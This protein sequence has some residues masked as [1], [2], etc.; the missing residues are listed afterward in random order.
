MR[1]IW[2]FLLQTLTVSLVAGIILLVKRIFED[3]LSPRWQYG[4]W[5]LLAIRILIPVSVEKY[6][7]FPLPIYIEMLKGQVESVMESHFSSVYV[8]LTM[9]FVWPI[10]I[11]PNSFMDVLFIVYIAGIFFWIFRYVCAHIRL[12]SRL[13]KGNPVSDNNEEK[14]ENVCWKYHLKP[15]QV[16][17][18]QGISSA[19][20]C[21]F[22]NPLLV[23]PAEREVNEKVL[24]HELLHLKYKDVLQNMAWCILRCL[25]W[26]NP[27]LYYV[28]HRIENDMESLCDQRVLDLLEGEERREYGKIL[29][30]M[31]NERYA[32]SP[33]T[34]SISNG[35]KNIKRRI[36]AIVRFKKYPKGMSLVSVCIIFVLAIPVLVGNA[37]ELKEEQ[38]M[39]NKKQEAKNALARA[40]IVRCETPV[41]ALDTYAKAILSENGVL[42]ATA[43]PIGKMEEIYENMGVE[44]TKQ[45]GLTLPMDAWFHDSGTVLDWI[46]EWEGYIIYNLTEQ[47][48]GS[49]EALLGFMVLPDTEEN[50][51]YNDRIL[52]PV[53]V[54]QEYGWV[55][56][57]AGEPIWWQ[58]TMPDTSLRTD[59]PILQKMMTK[60]KTGTVMIQTVGIHEVDNIE[61]STEISL[62]GGSGYFDMTPKLDATAKTT[63][64]TYVTYEYDESLHKPGEKVAVVVTNMSEN[65]T[66]ICGEMESQENSAGSH[67]GGG[68]WQCTSI[69]TGTEWNGM[70]ECRGYDELGENAVM[71]NHYRVCVYLDG[72]LTEEIDV[73]GE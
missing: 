37:Y 41:G 68:F 29:L 33:G 67:S 61:E 5:S 71:P 26:C 21:G 14:I 4:I 65:K 20:I 60:G 28:F 38:Y 43:S 18:M 31:A 44:K 25:H 23:L 42:L 45:E 17:E 63:L 70:L 46:Q 56:S 59:F 40:R 15:C 48:D 19:F 8:P 62:F 34:S 72:K 47:K 7:M 6:I 54:E 51:G 55:V 16:V 69:P 39:P 36:E 73:R 9:D 22:L 27:F 66:C 53:K 2:S 64:K 10:G 11:M 32:R 12:R 58:Q 3:K 35:G 30:G 50:Q 24:L 13:K 1:S 49:Y 52:F 57:E